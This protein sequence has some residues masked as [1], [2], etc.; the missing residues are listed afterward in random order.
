M[1]NLQISDD[2]LYLLGTASGEFQG[3][4]SHHVGEGNFDS[5][6]ITTDST[7][8]KWDYY[9]DRDEVPPDVIMTNVRQYS[10]GEYGSALIVKN[11][12]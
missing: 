10:L 5:F 7:L 2:F 4:A 1:V 8:C 9:S 3:I 12:R 6:G 11:D